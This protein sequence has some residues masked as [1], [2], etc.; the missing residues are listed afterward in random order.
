MPEHI[1]I[2]SDDRMVR[3][4]DTRVLAAGAGVCVWGVV[5]LSQVVA[6]VRVQEVG[7]CRVFMS[8]RGPLQTVQRACLIEECIPSLTFP[9]SPLPP[10]LPHPARTVYGIF[11]MFG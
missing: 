8:V 1:C 4:D 9:L 3:C 6:G 10:S 7:S 2:C 5:W 11:C